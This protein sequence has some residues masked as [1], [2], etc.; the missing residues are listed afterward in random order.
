MAQYSNARACRARLG[1]PV[2]GG[3]TVVIDGTRPELRRYQA[4]RYQLALEGD[5]TA[6]RRLLMLV[7][8][9]MIFMTA[10]AWAATGADVLKMF[11][12]DSDQT[13]EIA[14]VINAAAKVFAQISPEHG[15]PDNHLTLER[16]ET[17]GRLTDD[18]WKAVNKDNDNTLEMDEWLTIARQRFN[19]ADANKDGKLT[20]QELDSAAGQLLI[21]LIVK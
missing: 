15:Y 1:Y 11:N 13:L 20:V 10:P 21:K 6:H 9:A 17:E 2:I 8:P 7:A 5:M 19:A 12:R 3:R 16:K 18:D 4:I 14:E